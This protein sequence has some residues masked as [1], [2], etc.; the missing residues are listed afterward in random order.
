MFACKQ[1]KRLALFLALL[2]GVVSASELVLLRADLRVSPTES[3][4]VH[5]PNPTG[6][7]KLLTFTFFTGDLFVHNP[8][9]HGWL[10]ADGYMESSSE[11]PL[12]GRGI[13]FGK[14]HECEGVGYEHFGGSDG[15][16]NEFPP[17]CLKMEFEPFEFYDFEIW[18]APEGIGV[19]VNDEPL[20]SYFSA[21]YP[22]FD[23]IMGV[24][25][26]TN[27]SVYGIF[28]FKQ[29]VYAH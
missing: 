17:Q 13:T 11:V 6:E 1:V 29:I 15:K 14:T 19:K 7:F 16:A 22:A 5:R 4:L 9:A 12:R 3:A 23:T 2:T 18:V 8:R 20:Y 26:D 28:N 27:P 24:A 25:F 10:I 21:D